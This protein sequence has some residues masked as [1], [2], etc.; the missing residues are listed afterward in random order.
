[1]VEVGTPNV[2]ENEE[3]DGDRKKERKVEERRDS[4]NDGTSPI[5]IPAE[6]VHSLEV[7]FMYD[8]PMREMT[9]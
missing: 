5:E 1:M 3:V 2:V 9:V 4:S 7:A 6:E 8:A